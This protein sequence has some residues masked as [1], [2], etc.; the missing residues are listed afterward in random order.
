MRFRQYEPVRKI[1]PQQRSSE[2]V[3]RKI[4]SFVGIALSAAHAA[5]Q[6]IRS[7]VLGE[8]VGE[9]LDFSRVRHSEN[10]LSATAH[11]LL[12]LLNHGRNSAVEP[13]GG[14]RKKSRFRSFLV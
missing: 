12:N 14:L 5:S 9:A 4:R 10:H 6:T 7:V 1:R 2:N 11:Q 3:A 13:R 8:H